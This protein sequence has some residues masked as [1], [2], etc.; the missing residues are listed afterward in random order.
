MGR[1]NHNAG[2]HMRPK[3][4]K[5][6]YDSVGSWDKYAVILGSGKKINNVGKPYENTTVTQRIK[7]NNSVT[8]WENKGQMQVCECGGKLEYSDKISLTWRE[9][10][11]EKQIQISGKYCIECGKKYIVRNILLSAIKS[12][13]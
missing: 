2:M 7:D 11:C 5:T 6:A 12:E 3:N 10:Q 9:G 4:Y 1:D 8:I 13:G